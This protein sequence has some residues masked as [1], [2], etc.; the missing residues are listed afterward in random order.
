MKRIILVVLAVLMLMSYAACTSKISVKELEP[1]FSVAPSEPEISTDE[2][3]Q[4]QESF[5]ELITNNTGR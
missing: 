2:P 1:S 3:I 5:A 4:S